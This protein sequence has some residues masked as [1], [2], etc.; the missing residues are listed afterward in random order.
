[1]APDS[2]NSLKGATPPL[3]ARASCPPNAVDQP[4]NRPQT[5]STPGSAGWTPALPSVA[6]SPLPERVKRAQLT[7][8]QVGDADSP[9]HAQ[10]WRSRGYLPHFNQPG[11]IQAVTFRLADAM[12][13]EQQTEWQVFLKLK[14]KALCQQKIQEYLDAGHGSCV[15]RDEQIAR[16]VEDALLHFDGTRYRL[17]AWVIMPNHVHVVIEVFAGYPLAA[18]LHSWKSFTANAANRL[19]GR[20]GPFWEPEYHDRFVRDERH[21]QN[22]IN[23]IHENPVKAHL[24]KQ[25]ELWPW[26][27]ARFVSKSPAGRMPALPGH[28][29]PKTTLSGS[30]GIL[31]AAALEKGTES[32]SCQS[33]SR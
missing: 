12:P 29:P 6:S 1:M 10:G 17:I 15:L 22:A 27:S 32:E 31:P 28:P 20:T 2:N 21:L 11:I 26:S 14:D 13:A 23:Y 9:S 4:Q 18:I 16:L 3:G 19:L 7:K 25:A 33:S 8:N 5:G 30:S 24:A